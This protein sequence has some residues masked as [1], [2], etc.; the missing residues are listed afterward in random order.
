MRRPIRGRGSCRGISARR[1][2]SSTA[3]LEVFRESS[4]MKSPLR[5]A[6]SSDLLAS[7]TAGLFETAKL[8]RVLFGTLLVSSWANIWKPR[9]SSWTGSRHLSLSTGSHGSSF[10]SSWLTARAVSRRGSHLSLAV[11]G[12]S[13]IGTSWSGSQRSRDT[14]ACPSRSRKSPRVRS[15][16]WPGLESWATFSTP[17][18]MPT[19]RA[20]RAMAS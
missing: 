11:S 1:S 19:T 4:W 18:R 20:S 6:K 7:P 3:A 13:W 2:S 10:P 17:R 16:P 12:A 15:L 14:V 8:C 9:W 5:S